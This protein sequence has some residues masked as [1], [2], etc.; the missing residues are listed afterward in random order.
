[1]SS[2]QK[3]AYSKNRDLYNRNVK[4]FHQSDERNLGGRVT[5]VQHM[6]N[7]RKELLKVKPTFNSRIAPRPH[8]NKISKQG[9]GKKKLKEAYDNEEVIVAFKKIA[10]T[11]KGTFNIKRLY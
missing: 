1:M 5:V 8:V 4:D 10:N 2:M 6:K 9:D 3:R 7:H 11:K